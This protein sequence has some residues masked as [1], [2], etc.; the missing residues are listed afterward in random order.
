LPERVP[1]ARVI[2][3]A[4]FRAALRTFIRRTDRVAQAHGLTPQWY[5][6]LLMVKG[7]PD[8]SERIT[9]G[10]AAERLQLSA[11]SAT[12]LVDRVEEQGLLRRERSAEDGRVVTLALT[13]E[14]ERRLNATLGDLEADRKELQRALEHLTKSFSG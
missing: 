9:V 1:L 7:A 13:R 12:E 14:G 2:E 6:L 10:D 11:N 5:L 3:V 8:G 4:D